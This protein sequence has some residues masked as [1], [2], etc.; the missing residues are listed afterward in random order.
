MDR[1]SDNLIARFSIRTCGFV[2]SSVIRGAFA[3]V[4]VLYIH[5]FIFA[6]VEEINDEQPTASLFLLS[7]LSSAPVENPP[8]VS[9]LIYMHGPCACDRVANSEHGPRVPVP[10]QVVSSVSRRIYRSP[11]TSSSSSCIV[12]REF[13]FMRF[14]S[15]LLRYETIYFSP[16]ERPSLRPSLEGII[17]L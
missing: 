14:C 9:Y 3:S 11:S 12:A 4:R 7:T 5:R 6:H 15:Y 10:I 1:K 17:D 2:I 16:P 13:R 8:A